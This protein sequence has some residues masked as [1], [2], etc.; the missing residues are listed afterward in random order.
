MTRHEQLSTG[1][2]DESQ[3]GS[4]IMAVLGHLQTGDAEL[5][6]GLAAAGAAAYAV[7]LDVVHVGARGSR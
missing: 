3:Q 6:G 4:M 2:A 7:V 5:L 1:W